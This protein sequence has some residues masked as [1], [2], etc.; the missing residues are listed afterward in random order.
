MV[1]SRGEAKLIWDNAYSK[2]RSKL[3][4]YRV[5][6]VSLDE[7]E[8]A[9]KIAAE[10]VKD[11]QRLSQQRLLL[12]RIFSSYFKITMRSAGSIRGSITINDHKLQA[13]D[14]LTAIYQDMEEELRVVKEEND[15]LIQKVKY[16]EAALR[17]EKADTSQLLDQLEE[18]ETLKEGLDKEISSLRDGIEEERILQT[19]KD[20]ISAERIK[21]LTLESQ[22]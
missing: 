3:L 10:K 13:S 22:R 20:E 15:Q 6:V 17:D 18:A 5:R 21:E 11:R 4:T 2:L 14:R 7:H 8:T 9:G 12:K 16:L 1:P 19:R